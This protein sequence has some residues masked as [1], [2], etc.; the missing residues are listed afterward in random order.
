MESAISYWN[1][2]ENLIMTLLPMDG[3]LHKVC[4]QK[5]RCRAWSFI[6]T[7]SHVQTLSMLFYPRHYGHEHYLIHPKILLYDLAL[8]VCVQRWSDTRLASYNRQAI[9]L[10][11]PFV[12][13][14]LVS[15]PLTLMAPSIIFRTRPPAVIPGRDFFSGGRAVILCVIGILIMSLELQLSHKARAIQAVEV[16]IRI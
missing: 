7:T 13:T 9:P 10:S 5:E 1:W 3:V 2:P 8:L 4:N 15:H 16:E 6:A 12:T 14:I 11:H